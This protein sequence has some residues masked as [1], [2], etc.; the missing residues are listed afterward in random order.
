MVGRVTGR[1][2]F[3]T[4]GNSGIGRACA[5][6]LVRE[7]ADVLITGQ[8][9]G[10]GEQ[11]ATELNETGPGRAVFWPADVR[12]AAQVQS[13]FA[14][15]DRVF[16]GLDILLNN[17]GVN[18]FGAVDTLSEA[19]WD[20]CF[21]TNLK[22]V[23]LCSREAS[24]RLRRRG[25]GV[26]IN[27]A[28]NAG[29]IARADDPAYCASKAGLIM[30]TRSMALAH[31]ADRVRVNAVCPG[32]ISNTRLLEEYV[33]HTPDPAAARQALAATAPLAA[34]LDRLITPEEVAGLVLYLCGDEAQM[35]TGAIIAIDGGKSAGLPR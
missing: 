27:N 25:G 23:F 7:G 33:S 13:A 32:P 14:E 2:A 20:A 22:G 28:S 19:D 1:V 6:A 16:G 9:A 29:L 21:D 34:A 35:M 8:N 30:L 11:V 26:I 10:R 15:L 3:I 24:P 18:A 4:G 12:D 31:A 5:L 17:A